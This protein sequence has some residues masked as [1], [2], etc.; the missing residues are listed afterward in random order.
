MTGAAKSG[1]L[2]CSGEEARRGE[3]EERRAARPLAPRSERQLRTDP[4]RVAHRHRQR[5]LVAGHR[6]RSGFTNLGVAPM[7]TFAFTSPSV[8]STSSNIKVWLRVAGL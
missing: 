2:R 1:A 7:P 6:L 3:D 8:R 5:R 4:G